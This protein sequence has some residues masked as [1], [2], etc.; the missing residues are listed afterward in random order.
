MLSHIFQ[1]FILSSVKARYTVDNWFYR[2]ADSTSSFLSGLRSRS[3][4]RP[5][6]VVGNG[7]SLNSTPLADFS[8][9]TSIGMNKIDLLYERSPWRPSLVVCANNLVVKQHRQQF[10][11]S[12]VPIFLAWKCHWFLRDRPGSNIHFYKSVPTSGFSL[13]ASSWVGSLSSTVTY[14]ALQFAYFLG[15]DPVI[16]VGVDHSFAVDT[17]RSGIARFKGADINHFDPN[18]FNHGS[19]WGLPDLKGNELSYHIAKQAF[20]NADRQVLD[21]TIGG[22]LQVFKKIPIEEAVAIAQGHES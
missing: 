20:E 9:I 14:A 6:L 5:L 4:G 10:L 19:Y 16:L 1:K 8:G 11:E 15:G 3:I 18:Y 2:R 22:Q 7:P 12:M 13:D 21:A 17:S